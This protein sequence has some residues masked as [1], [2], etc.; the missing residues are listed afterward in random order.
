M[1]PPDSSPPAEVSRV[2]VWPAAWFA[3]AEAQFTLAGI[4]SK[5]KF[6]HVISQLDHWYIM[7]VSQGLQ[8]ILLEYIPYSKVRH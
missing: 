6:C 1:E 4:S 7:Q 8:N 2:A 5:I 3:Q